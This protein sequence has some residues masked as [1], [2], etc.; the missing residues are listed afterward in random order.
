MHRVRSRR[1]LAAVRELWQAREQLAQRRDVSPGRILP[2]A[3]I[4]AASTA[5]VASLE[6]LLEL[7]GFRGGPARRAGRTWFQALERAGR[8]PDS[9][10]P[11][12]SIATD[13]PPPARA[14]ADKDPVAA[15]RLA[16]ARAGLSGLSERL[17]V[18]VENLLSPDT[19][20]RVLWDPPG[21]EQAALGAALAAYG[22]RPWQVQLA[23]PILAQS[24]QAQPGVPAQSGPA[25]ASTGPGA[26]SPQLVTGE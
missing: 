9:A 26:G 18:P 12:Q 16:A 23:A 19:V 7:P 10:L 25:G 20:R 1:Q 5:P 8:L 22:A 13:A 15:A 4:V 21:V 2:D 6:Q 24:M 3:A 14:W 11:A 17:A